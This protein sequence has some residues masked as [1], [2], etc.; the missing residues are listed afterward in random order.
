MKHTILSSRIGLY[1]VS[2]G[3]VFRVTAVLP[4]D[5]AANE[6]M[7]KNRD[8]ALIATDNNGFCYLAEQYGSVCPSI[9]LADHQ[10]RTAQLLTP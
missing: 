10:R 1:A 4:D 7:S 3:K 6:V 5:A 8:H 2:M 9:I